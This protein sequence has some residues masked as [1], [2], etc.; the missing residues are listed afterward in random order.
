MAD[1]NSIH[2]GAVIDAAITKTNNM[3]DRAAINLEPKYGAG[4]V[5]FMF[6]DA[7]PS[8]FTKAYPIFETAGEIGVATAITDLIDTAGYL[9][10]AQLLTLQTSGWEIASHSKSHVNLTTATPQELD[11]ELKLSKEAL[12]SNGI[13][14]SS[15]AY[16][17]AAQ[18]SDVMAAT[19]KYYKCAR[20]N[21]GTFTI[22][23]ASISNPYALENIQI[24]DHT[25]LN[26]YKGYIDTADTEDRWV[27]LYMHDIDAN[28]ETTLSELITY[29][30]SKNMQIVTL[31]RGI[32]LMGRRIYVSPSTHITESTIKTTNLGVGSAGEPSFPLHLFGGDSGIEQRFDSTGTVNKTRLLADANGKFYFQSGTEF[33]EASSSDIVFSGIY[34]SPL[35]F[36][37]YANGRIFIGSVPEY[38]DNTTAKAGGLVNG[39]VYR[40]GDALK[41][42]HA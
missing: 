23:A 20:G 10:T 24:D 7:L 28:D 12:E 17:L 34:G 42:A 30:Q 36:I 41:V 32:E 40:T 37:I 13:I 14:V 35:R 4:I 1:Y 18:N 15:F 33:T 27:I 5:T 16:P 22:N 11:D 6:D 9:T 19:A 31:A 8:A 26:T 3:N 25:L 21:N 39:D 29:V 2:T 38:A